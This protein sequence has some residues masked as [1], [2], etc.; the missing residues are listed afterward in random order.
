MSDGEHFEN[1]IL[2]GGEAG[3]YI[4][5]ELARAGRRTAVIERALVGGSCPNVACMPSKNVIRSAKVAELLRH[6]AGFG[7]R[8]GALTTDMEAVR[9]RKREMVEGLIGIHRTRFA[10]N[11]LEF[12]LGEGRFVAPRTIEV[13]LAEGGTRRL[14]GERVF[15][16]LGTRATIPDIPGLAASAPLTH[17]EALELDRLPAH[18]VVLGGGYVG[19]EMAQAFRRFG[20]QVTVVQH[21][22]QLATRED[23]DVAEAIHAIFVED[24]IEVVLGAE[25]YSVDGHSGDRVRLRMRT[26]PGERVIGGSDVLVSAGR[27]PNT[28]GIGLDVAGVELDS[29]GYV[30]VNE[31][32][33]TTAPS[34]WAM[35]D[36]AGSP[37][38]T[39]VAFDDFR[40]VRDNLAGRE[41]TTRDRLI[42]YC[43]FIDPQLA[44]VGLDETEAKRRGIDVRVVR[45]PMT[46]VLRARAIGEMRGFMKA[47]LD[48]RSDR[49]LGFTM[50][51]PEAGEVIAVV[52][53]AMLAGLPHTGLR[54][55]ILTHPTMAE[56]LTVLFANVPP[57][58]V[59]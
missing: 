10:T 1:V 24:G 12:V 58:L 56:G 48:A 47:L 26:A 53:T 22:S 19:L 9:Q 38:F 41:R 21:G 37:Q 50:L 23:P 33:E 35:G 5:W 40:V 4:A 36:C 30:K 28:Q 45:L 27:T 51:G 15:L 52:Q 2:G 39:H 29:R 8:T 46:S 49:I 44:R 43:V 13:R 14:E 20:S 17:V 31:R 11:G 25:T 42:P 7:V 32:L 55:A 16:N 18:L 57:L 54:D 59:S 34:V 3:K 6:T